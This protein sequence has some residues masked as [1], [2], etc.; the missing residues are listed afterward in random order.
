MPRQGRGRLQ[1]AAFFLIMQ[2]HK[3]GE[4]WRTAWVDVAASIRSPCSPGT[5]QPAESVCQIRSRGGESRERFTGRRAEPIAYNKD[6]QRRSETATTFSFFYSGIRTGPLR[7]FGCETAP[8]R[9]YCEPVTQKHAK[10]RLYQSVKIIEGY[11]LLYKYQMMIPR[12]RSTH[13]HRNATAP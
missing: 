13:T 8:L 4:D 6:G 2:A 7:C 3:Q 9:L 12:P 10:K 1:A 11:I 5:E